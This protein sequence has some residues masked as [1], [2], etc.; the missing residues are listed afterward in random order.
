[1]RILYFYQYFSTPKGGWGTRVYEFTRKWVEEGHDVVVITSVYSK[2][3]L[4]TNKFLDEQIIDNIKVK[5]VNV[6][7]DNQ[8][9]AI[10]RIFSWFTY[11]L[12]AIYYSLSLK[13]DMVV[14]SSG[15]ITAFL[16]GIFAK[17]FRR[18]KLI[19]EVRDLWPAGAIEM[20]L[21]NNRMLKK[22]LYCFEGLCYLSSDLI[23]ALSPGMRNNIKMRYPKVNVH[24][25]TNSANIELFS[26]NRKVSK[27]I[28]T[29]KYV[30]YTGNIGYVNNSTFLFD[31][32]RYLYK[33]GRK[34]IQFL[35]V[36]EGP[37]KSHLNKLVTDENISNFKIVDLMPKENLVAYLQNAVAS[38]VP[39]DNKPILDTSSPNKLFESLAAGVPVIQTTQ[40]WIKELLDMENAGFTIESGNIESFANLLTDI[41]DGNIDIGQMKIKAMTLARKSFDKNILAIDMLNHM[42]QI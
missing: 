34:D 16:P 29:G 31:T 19:L 11:T 15:P 22:I 21:I 41:F 8:Q 4:V 28:F 18:K 20:G 38:I 32:A 42:Q 27:K 39:L 30:I 17:W 14:A 12:F 7:I 3:D 40:G 13:C 10:R 37:M 23:I 6:R 33:I 25:V 1:M 2:S 9:R 5:I 36:G 24:S 35:L 26:S